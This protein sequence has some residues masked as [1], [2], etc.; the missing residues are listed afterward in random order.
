MKYEWDENKNLKNI[1]DHEGI[2]FEEAQTVWADLM[3]Q[4]Y[5]DEEHSTAEDR[6][7]IIGHSVKSRILMVVFCERT[8]DIIRI[9]SAR[10]ATNREI[11]DWE[12]DL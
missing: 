10:K 11:K 3:A 6:F 2:S 5:Y 7:I 8:E 1:K 4:E 12:G 9:I